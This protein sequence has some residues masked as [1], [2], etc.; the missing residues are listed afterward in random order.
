MS[1]KKKKDR[2]T[3]IGAILGV[4]GLVLVAVGAM[5]DGDPNTVADLSGVIQAI[6]AAFTAGG[7]GTIGVAAKDADPK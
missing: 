4:V 1:E 2:K 5:L 3:T 6:G 7:L